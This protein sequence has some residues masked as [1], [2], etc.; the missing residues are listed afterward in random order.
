MACS[1]RVPEPF[2]GATVDLLLEVDAR[3]AARGDYAVW[4]NPIVYG[5]RETTR[6]PVILISCDTM[7]ADHLSC[8]GYVRET[9]PNLD[10]FAKEAVLFENAITPETWTLTAH[11]SMLTGLYPRH[12]HVNASTNLAETVQTLPETLG[13]MGIRHRRIHRLSPVDVA[14]ERNCPRIRHVFNAGIGAANMIETKSLVNAWLASHAA[15]P[16]FLFYHNYDL[17]SS[18]T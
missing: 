18:N 6:T 14:I 4:G 9:S 3:R 16:F 2:A 12:H 7:R 5:H 11:T 15:A 13:K 1:G 10:A 8:Y 17:H